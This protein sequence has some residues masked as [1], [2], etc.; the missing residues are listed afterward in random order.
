VSETWLAPYLQGHLGV[1]SIPP[2]RSD[3]QGNSASPIR[4]LSLPLFFHQSLLVAILI[5]NVRHLL[6]S[7]CWKAWRASVKNEIKE[8]RGESM[9]IKIVKPVVQQ[10]FQEFFARVGVVCGN[11]AKTPKAA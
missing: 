3:R 8:E 1:Q 6:H 9:G 11:S 10:S 4:E 5:E 2:T 7:R